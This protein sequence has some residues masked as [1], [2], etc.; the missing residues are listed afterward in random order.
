M[1]PIQKNRRFI[2]IFT[3]K[4]NANAR[5][6]VVLYIFDDGH[7]NLMFGALKLGLKS[8]TQTH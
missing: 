6:P 4:P 3:R 8:Q 7:I 1:Y 2:E 5:Y